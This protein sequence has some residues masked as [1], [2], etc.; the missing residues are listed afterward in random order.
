[1]TR[2]WAAKQKQEQKLDP[3]IKNYLENK[4]DD[5]SIVLDS[6]REQTYHVLF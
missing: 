2:P 3:R 4:N 5:F 1:M 6:D